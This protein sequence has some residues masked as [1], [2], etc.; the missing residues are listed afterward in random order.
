[1]STIFFFTKW[2]NNPTVERCVIEDA[3][4]LSARLSG[5]L[6]PTEQLRAAGVAAAVTAEFANDRSTSSGFEF[7][8][9]TF[10]SVL[11]LICQRLRIYEI[12]S[13]TA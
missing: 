12:F 7:C 2:I 4:L 11:A 1:M 6:G 3:G 8:F 9:Q 10:R 13:H 5:R